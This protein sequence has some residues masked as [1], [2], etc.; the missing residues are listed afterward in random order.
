MESTLQRCLQRSGEAPAEPLHH[1]LGRTL[2]L[3]KVFNGLDFAKMFTVVGSG[4]RPGEGELTC[5]LVVG[6]SPPPRYARP[7]QR[8]GV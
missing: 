3:P 5:A 2:A 4:L 7:S 8:E 6:T 1:W